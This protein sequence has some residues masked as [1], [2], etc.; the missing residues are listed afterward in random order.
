MVD[1]EKPSLEV[2][3]QGCFIGLVAGISLELG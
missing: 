1:G 2:Y 3:K